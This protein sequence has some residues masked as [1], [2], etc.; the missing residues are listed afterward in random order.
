MRWAKA[1]I[2]VAQGAITRG[3]S[4]DLRENSTRVF[5]YLPLLPP[6]SMSWRAAGGARGGSELGTGL[7]RVGRLEDFAAGGGSRVVAR[8]FARRRPVGAIGQGF[9]PVHFV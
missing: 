6:T 5:N 2:S 1:A 7:A 9:R 3:H 4:I 8:R